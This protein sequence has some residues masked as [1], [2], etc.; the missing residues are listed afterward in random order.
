MKKSVIISLLYLISLPVLSQKVTVQVIKMEKRAVPEWQVMDEKLQ[1]LFSGNEFFGEDSVSFTLDANRHYFFK[2]S[3]ADIYNSDTNLYSLRINGEPILLI[4]SNIGP[5]DH[6]FPFFTGIKAEA[7]KITGGT[8]ADISA[9]PWQVYYVSGN[10]LCGGSIISENWVVTAAHCTRNDNGSVI[11]TSDMAIK[12]GATD[13]TDPAQGKVYGISEVIVHPN[14]N[15]QT[16]ENDIALLNVAGSINFPNATPIKLVSAYDV[17]NGATDP[18]VMVWI[19]GW[20]LTSVTPEILP[21]ILQKVQLPIVS[22]A[23][24]STVWNTIPSTDIM[25]GY[26]NGNKD[27][28]NGDS[29]GPLVVPVNTEYKLAGIVSWGSPNCNTYGAYTSVSDLETWIRINTGIA[30]EF[31]PPSPEGPMIICQGTDSSQYA[32]GGLAGATSFEWQLSPVNAGLIVG[33][34][35]KARVQWN[36]NYI[37]PATIW[38]RAIVN[39][40]VSEWAW[41]DVKVALKTILNSQSGDTVTCAGQSITLNVSG[42]GDN[43]IYKWFQNG[44]LFKSGNTGVLNIP[45]PSINSTGVYICNISGSCGSVSSDNINL[46]VHPLTSITFVSPDT[47]VS[48]GKDVTLEV[49]AKGFALTY[50]W[51]KDGKLLSDRNDS[52]LLLQNVN[53]NDIGLYQATVAG[54]CGTKISDTVYVYVKKPDYSREPEVFLWPTITSDKFNLALSNDEYYNIRIFSTS[55]KLLREQSKCR[56]QT[57]IDISEFPRGF[58]IVNVYNNN[59]RRSLKLIRE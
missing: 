4:N 41:L 53:A 27:A 50:Q 38:F 49:N 20:G 33:D 26:L 13:P 30:Q 6:F 34:S 59:F 55:G 1:P 25:A 11:S 39:N 14:Y 17:A 2:I 28:C 52:L 18:G 16:L 19:T 40:V 9:F 22:N 35:T 37:G 36:L 58:Y 10:N 45:A 21:T 48:F 12:V 15:S 47:D 32:I 5:G 24:A 29:G 3:V 54:Y 44:N 57:V 46:T 7:T 42:T 23:Q 43:L 56:F 51:Q 8:N 31:T